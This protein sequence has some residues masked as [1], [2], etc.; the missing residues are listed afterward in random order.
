[1]LDRRGS[2][3]LNRW[4]NGL[5]RLWL[6]LPQLRGADYCAIGIVFLVLSLIARHNEAFQYPFLVGHFR[7]DPISVFGGWIGAL[8]VVIGLGRILF[9]E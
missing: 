5:S 2:G 4:R 9:L 3:W 1:M 7:I 8:A 6:S